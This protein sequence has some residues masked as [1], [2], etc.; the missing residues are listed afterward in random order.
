[1]T[2][3]GRDQI[4]KDLESLKSHLTK[5]KDELILQINLGKM[6][7]KDELH[8]LDQPWNDFVAKFKSLV[9]SAEELSEDAVESIEKLGKKLED[10]YRDLKEKISH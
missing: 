3:R 6:E 9:D 8:K 4:K 1:M 5:S 7:A 2:K 10:K